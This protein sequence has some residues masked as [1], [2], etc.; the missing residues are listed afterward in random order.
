M[1]Y[2]I[3]F[4]V[5]LFLP[6]KIF[7][8]ND[9]TEILEQKQ[10][11]QKISPLVYVIP[12][13]MVSYG[14]LTRF[15]PDLQHLDHS[16]DKQISKNIHRQYHFDDYIQ[17]IPYLGIYGLDL[18]GVK[19]KHNLL[20]RTLVLG[21]AMIFCTAIVQPTKQLANITRP[22]GSNNHSFPSGHTATAFLGAHILF[23]E[24]KDT[25]PWIGVAGYGFAF[26]T[27]TMRMINRKHW[28]SDVITG[29]GVSILC[30]ELSYL[31]LT[32]WHKL[33]KIKRK[34]NGLTISPVVSSNFYGIGGIYMF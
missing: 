22:D 26:T 13:A 1:R 21:T 31:M 34:S 6:F 17:F 4:Y 9:T 23:R 7:A 15:T 32:V 33:F 20:D 3:L 12:T 10:K 27:A 2:I 29:A 19:A 25:S 14:I 5:I 16:I 30:V 24:Y 8:Q 11:T 18:C 28:L